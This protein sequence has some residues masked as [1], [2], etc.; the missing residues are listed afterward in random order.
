MHDSRE[1][2]KTSNTGATRSRAVLALF[3]FMA[4]AALA[5]LM[6]WSLMRQSEKALQIGKPAPDFSL[7]TYTGETYALPE[8]RGSVVV[9]NF[10]ASWC[11]TCADE[12]LILEEYFHSVDPDEVVVLGVAYT[13]TE[14]EALAYLEQ[15]GVTYPNGP[16]LG[17]R[18]S[19]A[20]R[21]RGVPETFIIAA[22]G[23]LAGIQIGPFINLAQ[24]ELLVT[25]ASR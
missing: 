5:V 9:L 15:Y 17:T 16:D 24:L 8:L 18:I 7:T 12:A 2:H 20:Y 1:R 3:G 21:L 19:E 25:S 6:G 23:T 13:D 4:V 11:V 14:K 10:W 22:D